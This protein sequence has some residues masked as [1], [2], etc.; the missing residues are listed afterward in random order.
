MSMELQT[1]HSYHTC[2]DRNE[3][4]NNLDIDKI[5][6]LKIPDFASIYGGVRGRTMSSPHLAFAWTIVQDAG[7]KTIIDLRADGVHSRLR[8]LCRQYGFTYF[9]YPVDNRCEEIESMVNL[10]PD[11]CRHIDNGKFYIACAMGLH[12]TD[13]ALCLY[14]VFYAANKGIEPP[15]IK[16][17]RKKHGHSTDKIMRV[18]NGFYKLLSEKNGLPPFSIEVLKK[19]KAIIKQKS[20]E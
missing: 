18:L 3:V 6:K 8:D 16:G 9:H 15:E 5:S 11:L 7:I 20:E 14:W 13:I 4:S 17:Y 2:L 12:R 19:R 10:Y 1:E